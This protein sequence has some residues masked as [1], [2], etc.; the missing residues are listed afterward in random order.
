MPR[1][2][3]LAT[4]ICTLTI[5]G[6]GI[7]AAYYKCKKRSAKF[8]RLARNRGKTMETPGFNAVPVCHGDND[9]VYMVEDNSTQYEE[10]SV[11]LTGEKQK[12][13][14]EEEAK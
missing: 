8:Y 12:Q 13:D 5:S 7:I 11:V 3:Y 6:V 1:E 9:E 10:V 4:M 14:Q 2:I